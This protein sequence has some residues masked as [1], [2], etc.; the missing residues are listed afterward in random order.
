MEASGQLGDSLELRNGG[1]GRGIL[2]VQRGRRK[3]ILCE[4]IRDPEEGTIEVYW[5]RWDQRLAPSE[6]IV[7]PGL[8]GLSHATPLLEHGYRAQGGPR[9]PNTT[10]CRNHLGLAD[11]LSGTTSLIPR[12]GSGL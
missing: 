5:R 7:L 8:H 1:S 11:A 9:L 2:E 6:P 3:G 12:K 4:V 10:G